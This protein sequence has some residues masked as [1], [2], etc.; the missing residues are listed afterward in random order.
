MNNYNFFDTDMFIH[1]RDF[2]P[3]I[4]TAAENAF[5]QNHPSSI[6]AFSLVELK[7]NYIQDL[8]LLH[9]KV[10]DA[11]CFER[12]CA[13]IRNSGGRRSYLMFAMLI[14]WMKD[15]SPHPWNMARRGLLTYIESQ[16]AITWQDIIQSVDRVFNDMSCTRAKEVPEDDD[17]TWKVSI[18]HCRQ[19]NTDC[20]IVAFMKS[21]DSE[22]RS[23]LAALN[24]LS[25]TVM[26]RELYKIKDI[27]K[28]TIAGEYPWEGQTCRQVGDLLIGLQ[29]KSGNKLISSNAKEHQ[30]LRGPGNN[31]RQRRGVGL[32]F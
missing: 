11:D 29:S 3:S 24:T 17:G 31:Q 23:L 12:A 18:P 30:Q 28:Q 26:T 22:L 25:S 10:S 32:G 7:G 2:D 14:S 21:F 19:N 20:N 27:V 16:L 1:M 6:S 4:R 5:D 13:R 15:F 9:R 8:I